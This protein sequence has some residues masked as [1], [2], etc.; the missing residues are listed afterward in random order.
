MVELDKQKFAE[1]GA[2]ALI[3]FMKTAEKEGE[4]PM[5][6]LFGLGALASFGEMLFEKKGDTDGG[7]E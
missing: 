1:I 5:F 2:K 4:R 3:Q 6:L 7:E